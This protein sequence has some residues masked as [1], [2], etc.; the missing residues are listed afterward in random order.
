LFSKKIHLDRKGTTISVATA[1]VLMAID[2]L[3][4]DDTGDSKVVYGYQIMSHLKEEYDWSVKSGTVYP[5]LKKL[6]R[7]L[8]I[9]KG[10]G[11]D[12]EIDNK[13]QMIFY[14]I[15]LK[16][17]KLA[18]K[19]KALNN[20][21]LEAA[22]SKTEPGMKLKD[23]K[24]GGNRHFSRQNFTEHYLTPFLSEF[25]DH[26][27]TL[28]TTHKNEDDELEH[29]KEEINSSLQKLNVCG[30]LLEGELRRIETLKKL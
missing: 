30:E 8:L 18:A 16:G 23:P 24:D 26:I 2:D 7:E 17:Q 11:Q 4:E 9:R 10:I 22:L 12:Y 27:A 5:I 25:T 20:E 3:T 13:R 6:N 28:V 19:I 14:K 21:A 15:T 1:L 29:L